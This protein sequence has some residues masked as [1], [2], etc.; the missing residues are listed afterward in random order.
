[1]SVHAAVIEGPANAA[2]I[3]H[4]W[5][6][7]FCNGLLG[8]AIEPTGPQQQNAFVGKINGHGQRFRPSGFSLDKVVLL[9]LAMS[10]TT[11][12][13]GFYDLAARNFLSAIAVL[14]VPERCT[15]GSRPRIRDAFLRE[16][17][18]SARAA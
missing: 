13:V 5:R 18:Q 7:R 1:M 15:L 2:D 6:A 8:Q 10:N 17:I 3:V 4:D 16:L 9:T 12:R 14:S 11:L